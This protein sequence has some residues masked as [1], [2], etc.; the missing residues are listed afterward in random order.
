MDN[1]KK[2]IAVDKVA[3][4][5]TVSYQCEEEAA[6]IVQHAYDMGSVSIVTLVSRKIAILS[7]FKYANFGY[8]LLIRIG[9]LQH[10][11][12]TPNLE[13]SG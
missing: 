5:G 8:F 13:S 12:F 6:D 11:G 1:P 4:D 9:F 3:N 2:I 7:L 10:H